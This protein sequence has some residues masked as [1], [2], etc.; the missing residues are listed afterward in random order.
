LYIPK[1][2]MAVSLIILILFALGLRAFLFEI[3]FEYTRHVLRQKHELFEIFLDCSF[4]NGFWSGVFVYLVFEGFDLI[5]P[6]FA[7]TVGAISYY[8]YKITK[9]L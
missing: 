5:L 2:V 8:I 6:F 9:N 1:G 3:K 4:C 7:I